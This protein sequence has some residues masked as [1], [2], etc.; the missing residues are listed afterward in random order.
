MA[1]GN[2]PYPHDIIIGNRFTG[3]SYHI[4]VG[5]E[6]SSTGELLSGYHKGYVWVF[7]F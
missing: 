6:D 2:N 5:S 7:D 1:I 4:P 3:Y